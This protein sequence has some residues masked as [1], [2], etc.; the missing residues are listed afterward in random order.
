MRSTLG[1]IAFFHLRTG[2]RYPMRKRCHRATQNARNGLCRAMAVMAFV[3]CAPSALAFVIAPESGHTVENLNGSLFVQGGG[4]LAIANVVLSG[5]AP[6]ER[7]A[8][9]EFPAAP[10][11][12]GDSNLYLNFFLRNIDRPLFGILTLYIFP[13]DGVVT[14]A[15]FSQTG[16]PV[17]VFTDFGANP[18]GVSNVSDCAFAAGYYGVSGTGCEYA[19]FSIDVRA[20]VD[21]L[22]N[23]G[24]GHIG[25]LFAIPG[26]PARYDLNADYLGSI[27]PYI[28]LSNQT[29]SSLSVPPHPVIFPAPEPITVALLGLAFAALGFSRRRKLQ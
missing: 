24:A 9:L 4:G 14:A 19:P 1:I 13:G 28:S 5:G 3:L 21:A 12:S 23:A 2:F 17:T 18:P 7:R 20:S 10:Q 16:D 8:I 6:L 11:L 25:F 27:S 29:L 26:Y 22:L 15:D